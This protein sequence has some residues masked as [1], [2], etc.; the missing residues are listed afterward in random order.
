MMLLVF[1]MTSKIDAIRDG[2]IFTDFYEIKAHIIKITT[3]A[4][5]CLLSDFIAAPPVTLYTQT[6]K[7]NGRNKY[8]RKPFPYWF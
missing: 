8:R 4:D 5:E 1:A 2:D 3:H 6:I 7:R